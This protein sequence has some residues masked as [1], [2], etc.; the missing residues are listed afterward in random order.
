MEN[1]YVAR[2]SR[3][4]KPKGSLGMKRTTPLVFGP[5]EDI[6]NFEPYILGGKFKRGN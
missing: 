2:T 4:G 3:M 1:P 5:E 6:G